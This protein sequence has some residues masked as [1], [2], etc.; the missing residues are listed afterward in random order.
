M[1]ELEDFVNQQENSLSALNDKLMAAQQDNQQ[2]RLQLSDALRQAANER[3]R[4]ATQTVYHS[5][6][7][8]FSE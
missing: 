4:S 1:N 2:L 8:L 5:V 3:E 7:L 6:R